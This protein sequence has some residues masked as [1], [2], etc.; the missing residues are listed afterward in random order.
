[1]RLR[2]VF[3]YELTHRLR[4]PST[5][6][7][8]LFLF[9]V[10]F[11]MIHIQ[12]DGDGLVQ[13]NAPEQ[14]AL[15][16][17]IAGMVGLLVSAG[18]FG[19]AAVRDLEAGMDPLLFTSPLRKI[20]YL[21]GRFLAALTVN[22]VILIAV[23]LGLVAA[24]HMPYLEAAAFGPF[25]PIAYVQG[26]LLF[27]LPNVVLGGTVLFTIAVLARQV[28][29]V[30][31]G[32]ISI[33]IGYLFGVSILSQ[34]DHAML[35][36]LGDPIGASSLNAMTQYWA[37]AERNTR[38]V[39]FPPNLVINRLFWLTVA[40]GA[41]AGLLRRFRFA[42][43]D[44]GGGRGRPRRAEME[45]PM[46]RRDRVAIP[47]VAGTFSARTTARQ[48]LSVARNAIAEVVPTRVFAVVLLGCVGLTMLFG[49]DV[50]SSVFDTSTWPVTVLV[51][52]TVLNT[53]ITPI[54]YLLT[55]VY[56]GELVWKERDVGVAEIAD[57]AP[58]RGGI[59]LLGRFLALVVILAMIHGAIMVSG[60]LIQALQGYY[61]FEV[62]LYLRILL[63]LHLID[64]VL[65][66]A[67]AMTIH[68][69]VNQKYLGHLIALMALLHP[70]IVGESGLVRHHLLLYGTDPGWTYS[71]MNGFG[72]FIGPYIWFKLYWAAWALLLAV[73]ATLFLV[74][75]H[76]PGVRRRLTQA[77]ARFAGPVARVAGV[78]AVLIVA[79]GSAIFYNTN[80]L[81]AHVA[82]DAQGGPQAEYERRYKQFEHTPQP[83]IAAADLRIEIYPDE[84]AADL[85]GSYRLV[86]RTDTA[87]DSVHVSF[88][89]PNVEARSIAFDRSASPVL[90]DRE[91]SYRIYALE[92]PLEPG[93]S[94]RLRFDVAFRPRG[95]PNSAIQT[96]VVGN[97]ARFNRSWLPV[98][99]YQRAFELAD[100][101]A[102]S[103]F[104]LG[105][106]EALPN[107]AEV[108]AGRYRLDRLDADL[109]DVSMV[110]G[111]SADQTAITPGV[112]RRSWTEN[113]RRYFHYETDTPIS[114]GG[115]VFS[116]GY[117][118]R[119]DRWNDV[120]LSV[121]HHPA[122]PWTL[123]ATIRS[124]KA[125]LEY[126]TEQFGPYRERQ[127]R[128]VEFPR[129]GGFGV[130]HPHT[131]AF[132]E[133]YFLSRVRDGEIDQAFY[134]T[135]HE[136]AHQWWGG[137][138]RGAT[139]RG[140]GLLT[141]SLANYSAMMVTEKTFGPE[142]GRRVYDFQMNRYLG[143][144]ASQSREAPL[145]EVEDQPYL[146]YRKGAIALYTLQE[147]IGEE[148]VNGALRRYLEKFGGGGG[149]HPTSLDLYAEL[150]A[151]TPDT[152]HP[153]LT[154]LFETIT[155]W[156]VRATRAEAAPT[157]TGAYRLTL[158]VVGR[159]VR[160]DSVGNETEVPMDE[161]VEIGVFAPGEGAALGEPL[162]LQRHRIRSGVQTITVTVPRPPGRAG[163][164]PYRRLIDRDWGNNMLE[165]RE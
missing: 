72:G 97:G 136:V 158:D 104:G 105:P 109:V 135:A 71:D 152:L 68:V 81:N 74:R 16:S 96:D 22:A 164:D 49:W 95:F 41:F 37:E 20:E 54:F 99:G 138:V 6:I 92:R 25:R 60:M 141:E 160:A 157:G 150:R 121:Y 29:P 8:A 18:L 83:A 23:P 24:S 88:V 131:I 89:D 73:L 33:F 13:I 66:A 79:L 112:L 7:Y 163:V 115:T 47:R 19:D 46:V 76:Q 35:A 151:V 130:A 75:G 91:T 140:H 51:I 2:E 129:Y 57:A 123:D 87:I 165:V 86:N 64:G 146:A 4:S 17:L 128:V 133:D 94:L 142:V 59:V 116:A 28:I 15:G 53:P 34:T 61:R 137:Q 119:E 149:L 120:A 77:R 162:H 30:Y 40:A 50:G 100:D 55:T 21:G 43:P 27:L 31:L 56:A 52:E 127:L 118:V 10:A 36:L 114:F 69:I 113:G 154:D 110:I 39:G 122:H 85:T 3:R 9:G 48:A 102:R 125:S 90:E 132:S 14:V 38:L 12:A 126:F 84:P 147:R 44:V 117:A 155:L 98:V 134:G 42:H 139:A 161:L 80:V 63:G 106:R 82:P 101:E 145:L 143:G 65:L 78:A 5:W 144:R 67:L 70:V 26:Y 159:K 93:E 1:M 103:R 153:L 11:L 111:T 124:M 148:R 108:G 58:V 156:D 62:G 107:P 32:A 45:A